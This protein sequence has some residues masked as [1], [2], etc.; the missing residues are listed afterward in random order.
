MC[1]QSIT[2]QT[3]EAKSSS[4]LGSPAPVQ[5]RPKDKNEKYS[6][7]IPPARDQ[8]PLYR[9]AKHVRLLLHALLPRPHLEI[10]KAPLTECPA[11]RF[12]SEQ[13]VLARVTPFALG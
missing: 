11:R 10:V 12:L 8:A 5:L 9:V 7:A 6:S 13:V 2:L 3:L 1:D 4:S